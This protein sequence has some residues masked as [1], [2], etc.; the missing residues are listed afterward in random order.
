MLKWVNRGLSGLLRQAVAGRRPV[1][2]L[3]G[4]KPIFSNCLYSLTV[5]SCRNSERF[6][7]SATC[8]FVLSLPAERALVCIPMCGR[9][10]GAQSTRAQNPNH[11]TD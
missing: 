10:G 8:S 11:V 9:N 3:I 2:T 4:Y 6:S 1:P 5:K 7:P